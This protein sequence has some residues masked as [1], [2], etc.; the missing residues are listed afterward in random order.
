MNRRIGSFLSFA[1]IFVEI[2]TALFLTPLIIKKFGQSEYGVYTL[3]VS[4]TSYLALLDLGIGHSVVKF[5]SKYRV[6]E[7]I[8]EQNKFIGVISLYYFIIACVICA[9]GTALFF[10]FPIAFSKGLSAT[11]IALAQKLLVI[12]VINIAVTIGTSGF[13]NIVVA[14]ENFWVTKGTVIVFSILRVAISIFMLFNGCKSV[15]ICLINLITTIITRFLIVLYCFVKIKIKPTLK[16]VNWRFVLEIISFSI[17]VLFQMVA[18]Q[19]NK[20]ADSI[21]IGAIV[22]ESSKILAVYGV[23]AQINNYFETF[24]NAFNGVLMPGIVRKVE[25]KSNPEELQSEMIKLSRINLMFIGIVLITFIIQGK[26][27]I[28]LW[29]GSENKEAYIVSLCLMIPTAIMLIQ[30]CGKQMLWAMNKHKVQSILQLL[31]VVI[32]VFAT[33]ALIKWKPLEGAAL[34]T[35]ISLV[36]GEVVIMQIVLKKELRIHLL[37]YYQETLKGIWLPLVLSSIVGIF[38]LFIHLNGWIGFILRCVI[39]VFVY[40]VILVNLGMNK[41]EKNLLKTLLR[42]L[43]K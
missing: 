21:L 1:L 39:M 23:G 20:M 19:M 31:I 24:G 8:V 35:M 3:I 15:E 38:T 6:N 5:V 32:N 30:N 28:V 27:F 14:Y 34:G 33:I 17:F 10:L 11:E 18:S 2:F 16:G 7:E 13:F 9:I 41:N 22:A 12:S 36:L 29:S 4:I 37:K 43:K 26:D 25:K 42:K 40:S